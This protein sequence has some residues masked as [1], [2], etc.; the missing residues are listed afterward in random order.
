[1]KINCELPKCLLLK[2][3]ELNEMDFILFHLM[4]KDEDY[5]NWAIEERRRHPDRIMILDN[6]AYEFS[7]SGEKLDINAFVEC[8]NTLKPT[9][10]ILPDVL[11]NKT[12][13]LNCTEEFLNLYKDKI[14]CDAQPMAVLQGRRTQDLLDCTYVY[15]HK[16]GIKNICVPF[17]IDCFKKN[18][19]NKFVRSVFSRRY[20]ER[21]PSGELTEDMEY[22][23]GRVQFVID[24]RL[25]LRDFDYVHFLGSHCPL[26]KLFY[27]RFDSMD[28]G[29]PVKI[30]VKNT[31]L[32][33]ENSKPQ[34]IIDDFLN[35]NLSQETKNIICDNIKKFKEL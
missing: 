9:Y 20:N 25:L 34:I 33:K 24:Y 28:T 5:R 22:A 16:L 30:G 29:Y 10:Y 17:H 3:S 6:S 35:D 18:K 11:G 8:I 15:K 7:I 32:F 1:M 27:S 31:I 4:H 19:K 13:T 2:N 21:N 12:M 14:T 26:E 23:M